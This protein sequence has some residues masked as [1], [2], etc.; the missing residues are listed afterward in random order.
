MTVVEKRSW[1]EFRKCGM[2]WLVN[3]I[4]Q[5]FGWSIVLIVDEVTKDI[6]EVFPARVRY[7]GFSEEDNT[8]GYIN[9]SKFM[10]DNAKQLLK[11]AEG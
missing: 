8:N 7:R 10:T 3:M 5:V 9:L 2:L 4:L 1:N 11:E 6:S